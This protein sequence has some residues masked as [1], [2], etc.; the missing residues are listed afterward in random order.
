MFNNKEQYSRLQIKLQLNR[1]FGEEEEKKNKLIW[2][3]CCM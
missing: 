1:K 2:K 3:L